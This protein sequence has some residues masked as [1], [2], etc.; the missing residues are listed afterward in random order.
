MH[1]DV[2]NHTL[3]CYSRT[4]RDDRDFRERC[5]RRISA[6]RRATCGDFTTSLRLPVN[7]PIPEQ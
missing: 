7:E 3:M 6:W 2:Y 4:L 5:Q 1:P